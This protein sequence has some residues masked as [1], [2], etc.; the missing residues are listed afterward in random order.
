[1]KQGH[2]KRVAV[3][4]DHP[5]LLQSDS[6]R[7]IASGLPTSPIRSRPRGWVYLAVVLDLFSRR[8][9]GWAI[10]PSLATVSHRAATGGDRTT[11]AAGTRTAASQRSRHAVH[12]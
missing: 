12:E 8:V 2:R 4:T 7:P 11:S 10:G 9:V 5:G 3:F 1:M 6:R